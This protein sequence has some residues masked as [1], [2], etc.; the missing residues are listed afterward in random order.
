[1]N[2]IY[3]ED[4]PKS[5]AECPMTYQEHS[6]ARL[7][8]QFNGEHIEYECKLADC[9]LKPLTD[10]LAEERK[11]VCDTIYKIIT[12]DEVWEDIRI[13]WWLINGECF[14]LKEILDQIERGE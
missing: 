9:P 11:R 3:V 8:C 1:M 5:C 14:Q 6:F 10:R 4:L 7:R 12:S 13:N 2:N